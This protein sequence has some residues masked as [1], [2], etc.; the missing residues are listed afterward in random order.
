MRTLTLTLTTLLILAATALAQNELELVWTGYGEAGNNWFG[1]GI[2]GGDFNDDR[3]SDVLIGAMGCSDGQ[4]KV[5]LYTGSESFFTEPSFELVGDSLADFFGRNVINLMDMSLDG[6]EDFIVSGRE[7]AE[8]YYGGEVFDTIPDMRFRK[9]GIDPIYSPELFGAYMDSAG[10]VNGDEMNDFVISGGDYEL[11]F[12]Y[13]EIYFEGSLLDT[14]PDWH[15][16]TEAYYNYPIEVEGLGDIND[17]GFDDIMAYKPVPGYFPAMIFL[18]GTDM[19]TIPDLE[20]EPNLISA[21]GLGDINDDGYADFGAYKEFS[22]EPFD[23]GSVVY[24]G[25]EDVDT[26]PDVLLEGI[27]TTNIR[28]WVFSHGDINGDGL[29]DVFCQGGWDF[30]YL[31]VYLGSPWFNGTP[32]WWYSESWMYDGMTV[33]GVGD[34]NHDGCDEV[35]LGIPYYS[36]L[37]PN[38]GEAHLFA[39]NPDLID[40]GA[41]V[42]P[43][44]LPHTPGWFKLDQNFPNPFNASTTIH[45]ELGKISDVDLTVYDL[46]GN[47]I[48]Q[49]ISS[50]EMLPGG[51]NISWSGIGRYNQP[52]SSGIYLLEMQ[53]DKFKDIRKMVLMR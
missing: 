28:A 29:S 22:P 49:L 7:R 20:I 35:A 19:D 33:S 50:R 2:A 53:V 3:Y 34:V 45:F 42:V 44:D 17:D 43:G 18:G 10:D 40:L 24:F 6:I 36:Y 12:T 51:Y 32:D 8:I 25:S 4:G 1:I 41:P 37:A 16:Y 38:K 23:L 46:Q 27:F 21:G 48:R 30:P 11:G 9:Y 13:V 15:Y 26:I 31:Y 39:G 47:S 14:L 5:N 52:V